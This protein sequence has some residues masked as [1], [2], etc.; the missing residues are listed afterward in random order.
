MSIG[1][2]TSW[3]HHHLFP[4]ED[5]EPV[6]E[7]ENSVPIDSVTR[8]GQRN[9]CPSLS[10][11][12]ARKPTKKDYENGYSDDESYDM[13]DDQSLAIKQEDIDNDN[14]SVC[15]DDDRK[16]PAQ[17]QQSPASIA[18]KQE[19]DTES[20]D[21]MSSNCLLRERTAPYITPKSF[22]DE[23]FT[24]IKEESLEGKGKQSARKSQPKRTVSR[25]LIYDE[26]SYFDTIDNKDDDPDEN[27]SNLGPSFWTH[28]GFNGPRTRD[29]YYIRTRSSK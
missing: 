25:R 4:D 19:S 1:S 2:I 10:S 22:H 7:I 26:I 3:N 23:S 8:W 15:S 6:D 29:H 20:A 12:H 21:A 14:Y 18:I 17:V 28:R 11:I 24:A 5:Y 9:I 13:L 16:R 27:S